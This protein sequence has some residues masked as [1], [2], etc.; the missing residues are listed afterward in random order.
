MSG[1]NPIFQQLADRAAAIALRE[2]AL[3][4][5]RLNLIKTALTEHSLTIMRDQRTRMRVFRQ[6]AERISSLLACC[7]GGTL[8]TEA[9][10]IQTPL[11]SFK[12][13]RL[14]GSVT[15]VPIHRAG[16]VMVSPFFH[17]IPT[18]NQVLDVGVYRD[19]NDGARPKMYLNKIRKRISS[20][21]VYIV[22]D[23]MLATAG[24]AIFT[25]D[26][27]TRAGAINIHYVGIVSAPEGVLALN[28]AF[29]KVV[30]WTAA[31]DTCLNKHKFIYKGLGDF[32]DRVNGTV[33][34][35]R[36]RK[37]MAA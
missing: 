21:R 15:L 9:V 16:N 37:L 27:L 10:E 30:I 35:R 32:G 11:G 18:V 31:V 33:L 19:E 3:R 14:A 6:E 7:V 26:K 12:G 28:K 8:A 17:A 25:I 20:S 29:P 2:K 34:Y 36:L 24:S 1:E 23:P 22:T 13:S 5:R 4:C